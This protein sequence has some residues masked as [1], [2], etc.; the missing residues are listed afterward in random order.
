[1][2]EQEI[3]AVKADLIRWIS[4]MSDPEMIAVLANLKVAFS[5]EDGGEAFPPELFAL[6]AAE[7]ESTAAVLQLT[8]QEELERLVDEMIN[9]TNK[10]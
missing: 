7:K 3:K 5:G 10:L 8:P 6:S 2:D 9:G 1:M 4:E